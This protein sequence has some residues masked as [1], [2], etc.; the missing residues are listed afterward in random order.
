MKQ[1][2]SLYQLVQQA[3]CDYC[4]FEVGRRVQSIPKT[5]FEAFEAGLQPYA[6][7]IQQ[8]A[9]FAL[10]YWPMGM[11]DNP[12]IWFLNLPLDEESLLIPGSRNHFVD[13]IQESMGQ[14]F[15]QNNDQAQQKLPDNPYI[16]MPDSNKVALVNAL[17][18]DKFKRANSPAMQA[19]L[20]YIENPNQHS[21]RELTV[22]G[23]ADLLVK[24]H[25]NQIQRAIDVHIF[26]WPT[27]L[28][29]ELLP[30]L[31]HVRLSKATTQR[32]IKRLEADKAE[33]QKSLPWLRCLMAS[34]DLVE[35]QEA[36]LNFVNAHP[37]LSAD[38]NAL[39]AARGWPALQNPLLM[40]AFLEKL[41]ASPQPI[42]NALFK[43]LVAIPRLR[44]SI[45]SLLQNPQSL[46]KTR[47]A[48][49]QMVSQNY[50]STH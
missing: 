39:I 25:D 24:T 15:A 4:V 3:G 1:V 13:I 17:I 18:K 12:F 31:E 50:G 2:S 32:L 44:R 10:V 20:T 47:Q 48:V 5:E 38:I 23:W 9:R 35:V 6:N 7:P 43:D 33:Q 26:N 29:T 21:W 28:L 16:K 45:L 49:T 46:P 30:L 34:S 42:F 36:L 22:Q 27:S 37:S 8:S 19:C 41:T 11:P 14:S 40:I